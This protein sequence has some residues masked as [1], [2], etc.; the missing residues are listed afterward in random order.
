MS[1]GLALSLVLV[2]GCSSNNDPG[3]FIPTED[4]ARRAL[5][6]ALAAWRDGADHGPVPGT[7]NP[8]IQFADT[9][10]GA[11]QRLTAFAIHGAAPGDGPRVFAVTL[12]LDRPSQAVKARYVVFG[13]DPVWVVRHEDYDMLAHWEHSHKAPSAGPARP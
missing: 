10:H 4:R 8:V 6:A 7:V 3:R 9:H 1:R 13:Q 2:L 12:T 11:A 5:E